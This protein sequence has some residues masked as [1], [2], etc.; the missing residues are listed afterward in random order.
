MEENYKIFGVKNDDQISKLLEILDECEVQ[1][2][3]IDFRDM[4]P[5]DEELIKWA[6]YEND[7]YPINARSSFFKKN[8]KF[9]NKLPENER[10]NWLRT[11]YIC[12][13][14]PIIES[15]D[16]EI[17]SIGG[18]PEKIATKVFSLTKDI[19]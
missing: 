19:D 16:G 14:R 17:L 6:E 3:F 18:R 4:P 9:F 2:D 12:L 8:K 15:E 5:S 7:D 1:Y 10:F 11:N 13:S